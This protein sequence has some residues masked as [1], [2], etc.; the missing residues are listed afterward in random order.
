MYAIPIAAVVVLAVISVAWSPIFAL[1]IAVPAFMAFLV[2]VGLSRRP[3]EEAEARAGEPDT[4]S[5]W[6]PE[7]GGMW[8][9]RRA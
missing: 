4:I 6:K 1:I 2:Y 8:G 3:D 7:H 5:R 9:E